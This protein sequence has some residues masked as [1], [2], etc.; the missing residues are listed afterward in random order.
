MKYMGYMGHMGVMVYMDC[1]LNNFMHIKVHP[2]QPPVHA[3]QFDVVYDS[4]KVIHVPLLV[5]VVNEGHGVH[6][7]H[8]DKLHALLS[9][10]KTTSGSC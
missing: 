7:M 5:H 9:A 8:A 2:E 4:L 10:A 1:T 6:G 3:D